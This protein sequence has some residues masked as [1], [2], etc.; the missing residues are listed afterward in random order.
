MYEQI[1]AEMS[2]RIQIPPSVIQVRIEIQFV[3]VETTQ[4]SKLTRI[5]EPILILEPIRIPEIIPILERIRIL[6][7]KPFPLLHEAALIQVQLE[8]RAEVHALVEALADLEAA[9]EE[10]EVNHYF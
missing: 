9:A 6:E 4:I 8:A 3:I 7:D 1:Q 5:R 10:V 2:V